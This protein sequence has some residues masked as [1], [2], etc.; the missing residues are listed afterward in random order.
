M[1]IVVLA[2]GRGSNLRALLDA[3]RAG[4]LGGA[5]VVAVISD[6]AGSGALSVARD[7]G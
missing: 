4:V 7:A 5:R 3:E 6:R 2:S 1:R